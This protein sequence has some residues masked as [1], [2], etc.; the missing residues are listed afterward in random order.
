MPAPLV[1]AALDLV[2]NTLVVTDADGT[3]VYV[4]KAFTT[5]T[6]YSSEVAIGATP[7]ILRSGVHG[8]EF[9][10]ALWSRIKAG[11]RWDGEIVNRRHDGTLYTDH[12]TITPLFDD[13]DEIRN[14]VAVKRD[15]STDAAALTAG[16][17][18]GTTH[19]D[20][21]GRL[22]YANARF[23]E[24]WGVPFEELLGFGW[25]DAVPT[26]AARD[27]RA[28]IRQ[29]AA[30]H[31]QLATVRLVTGRTVRVNLAPLD[32]GTDGPAGVVAMVEDVT[33]E[34]ARQYA[35]EK[36]E[37]RLQAL[38]EHAH[39]AVLQLDPDGIVRYATPGILEILGTPAA[40]LKGNDLGEHILAEDLPAARDD[41]RGLTTLGAKVSGTVRMRHR[42]GSLRDVAYHIVNL[43]RD[44][45]VG[46]LVVTL[47]DV[48]EAT[49]AAKQRRQ[50]ASELEELNEQLT[51]AGETRDHILD[52][53]THELRTPLTSIIGM[54]ELLDARWAEIDDDDVRRAYFGVI[55]RNTDRIASLVEDLLLTSG[56]RS[57]PVTATPEPL[58]LGQH[59]RQVLTHW[60]DAAVA[61]GGVPSAR[62]WCQA[63]HLE[64]ILESL[65]AN[66]VT[67]GEP[68]LGVEIRTTDSE[69][70]V[71]V[72]DRGAGVPE[73]I[74]GSLFE[75][76][77]QGSTGDRRTA[78]G[79][80]LG[81]YIARSL[82]RAN[83]GDLIHGGPQAR[84]Q[85]TLVL[86]PVGTVPGAP[87]RASARSD[88]RP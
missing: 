67:Y 1:R 65:L 14:F 81:L 36:S 48:T 80:G 32:V 45:A 8:D 62:V 60:P 84:S 82:A 50:Y 9:Y 85:F 29:A 78:Q 40:D 69:V 52:A 87:A 41:L 53:T 35:L 23:A 49:A 10:A 30:D 86:Q 39:D 38:V 16:S 12:T 47:T 34:V 37:R 2:E 19:L 44:D 57:S 71:T 7:A 22:V 66:A 54:V 73:H 88:R 59:I 70:L 76:F 28:T 55:E 15:V 43:I 13:N 24:L 20:G 58:D 21:K 56:L 26:A 64:T 42:D 31:E 3:I 72:E 75:P 68:P 63:D 79:L 46:T 18:I 51:F 25:F 83:G 4:N 6:G 33:E 17:P 74:N 27:L 5:T 11:H 77:V 61:V